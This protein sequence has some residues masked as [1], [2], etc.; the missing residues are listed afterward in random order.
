MS[1]GKGFPGTILIQKS[2]VNSFK[3]CSITN[4]M[5]GT[6]DD[7]LWEEDDDIPSSSVEHDIIPEEDPYN[8][9]LNGEEWDFMFDR[10]HVE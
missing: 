7:M 8:D 9:H 2:F 10:S 1:V 3:K 6:E 5:D 4:A